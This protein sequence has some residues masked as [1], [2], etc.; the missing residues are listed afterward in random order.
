MY[1]FLITGPGVNISMVCIVFK[2]SIFA[3]DLAPKRPC[4]SFIFHILDNLMD[5]REGEK[6]LWADILL[7]TRS[8]LADAQS[9]GE[10]KL[11]AQQTF[12]AWDETGRP[13]KFGEVRF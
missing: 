12:V 8:Y 4:I 11:M 10:V 1:C 2:G 3:A 13:R 7:V 6:R 9:S 5:E